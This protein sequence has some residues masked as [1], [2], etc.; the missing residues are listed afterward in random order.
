MKEYS[1]HFNC[2]Q[3]PYGDAFI[4]VNG[5]ATYHLEDISSGEYGDLEEYHAF[6]FKAKI[7][8]YDTEVEDPM[9]GLTKKDLE[10]I[11]DIVV[12]TLNDNYELCSSLPNDHESQ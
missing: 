4:E 8:S 2:L 3:I 12:E 10:K 6:F 7:R 5:T 9:T 11:S 1:Y